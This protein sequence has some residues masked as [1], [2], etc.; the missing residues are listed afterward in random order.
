M[1][2]ETAAFHDIEK[3]KESKLPF[4]IP[5]G[6]IEYHGPHC[7]LGCDSQIAEGI[8]ERLSAAAEIVLAP[9]IWY[10]VASYAVAGPEKNTI[11]VDTDVFENYIACI[12]DSLLNGGWRNIYFLIHHQFENES[13][14]PMTLA[15]MKAGKKVTMSFLEK[16][17][18]NGWWGSNK[19]AE[20]YAELDTGS[21]PFNW[22]KVLP[23]MS[24]RA[25]ALTGYDHAGK[26]E[27]SLLSALRP[28]AVN[29]ER[30]NQSDEWFIDSAKFASQ[31]IGFEMIRLSLE[32]LIAKIK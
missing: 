31:E 3:A 17:R 23:C 25:Q 27:C 1:R 7:A 9:T 22:I 5:V 15:C 8:A 30:L 24:A 18:G 28:E 4:V 21:N 32:D 26:W 2:L 16:T 20:Y 11:Q 19:N 6:T 14:M 29:L 10:G 12:L 13:L